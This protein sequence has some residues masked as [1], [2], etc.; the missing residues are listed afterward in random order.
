M[1][2]SGRAPSSIEFIGEYGVD[3]LT[4]F[5]SLRRF[6]HR[7]VF[8]PTARGVAGRNVLF[9]NLCWGR[10]FL[11]EAVMPGPEKLKVVVINYDTGGNTVLTRRIR[12]YVRAVEGTDL[13]LGRFSVLLGGKPRFLGYF[14][15]TKVSKG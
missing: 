1:F 4:A 2:K 6:A 7:K 5:P 14:S 10:F 3:M 8:E 13:Y 9:R 15:L 11:E 12:D